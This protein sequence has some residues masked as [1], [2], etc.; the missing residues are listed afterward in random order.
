MDNVWHD[1]SSKNTEETCQ[2]ILKSK[3]DILIDLSGHTQGGRPDVLSNRV[4]PIQII[5]LGYPATSG[6]PTIDYRIGDLYADP[7]EHSTQ[8]TEK[9]LRLNHAMWNYT[10]W[11]DMP[12]YPTPSPFSFNK[13]ITCGSANNHAKIQTE[14]LDVWAKVLINTPESIFKIKSRGLKSPTAQ[15]HLLEFFSSKGINNDRIEIEHY[16]PTRA[17]HWRYLSQFDIALDTFPYNGTTTTCDLLNL[18]VPIVTRS[19]DSHVS[20]TTGSILDSLDLT[21][22]IAKSEN[23]FISICQ[24]KA[25]DVAQLAKLRQS[26][27]ERFSSSTLGHSALFMLDYESKIRFAWTTFCKKNQ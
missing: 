7:K 15:R 9:M 27:K 25:H 26:L 24:E 1:I 16:S 11:Y 23:E 21:S 18:G 22:W 17:L 3:I 13:K 4:A 2:L 20:R 5:Y 12:K 19:G 6:L 14:W 8:N 10:P